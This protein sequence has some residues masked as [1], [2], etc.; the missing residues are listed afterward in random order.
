MSALWIY[1]EESAFASVLHSLVYLDEQ[2]SKSVYKGKSLCGNHVNA[3]AF[4]LQAY[5]C[6]YIIDSIL[7]RRIEDR[8]SI[9]KKNESERKAINIVLYHS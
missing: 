6:W 3:R 7:W 4:C 9:R 2:R 1:D 5:K 8:N